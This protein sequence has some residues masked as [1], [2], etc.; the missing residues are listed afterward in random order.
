MCSVAT[1]RSFRHFDED[2][3][4]EDVREVNWDDLHSNEVNVEQIWH[5]FKSKFKELCDRHAPYVTVRK[6][7][8]GSPWI[9]NEYLSVARDRDYYKRKYD[10]SKSPE[11]WEKYRQLRNTANVLNKKL[12]KYYFKNL[13]I[14]NGGDMKKSWRVMKQLLPKK[15]ILN[16]KLC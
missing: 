14:E 11:Y 16:I 12:K 2:S 13:C 1:Y 8:R 3:F 6:R 10:K 5:T 9:T 4:K 7:S 15:D